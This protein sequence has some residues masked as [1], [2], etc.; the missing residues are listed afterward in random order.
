MLETIPYHEYRARPGLSSGFLRNLL[1]S[2]MHAKWKQDHDEDSSALA[3]GRYVHAAVLE[4]ETVMQC[5]IVKPEDMDRR[6]K[7]GRAAY[8]E[9]QA[10]GKQIVTTAELERGN[11]MCA[12]IMK[13][14]AASK[15][16]CGLAPD[17]VEQSAFWQQGG[18]ECKC[19]FDHVSR[20]E[21]IVDLKTTT[22]ANRYEFEKSIA[23]YGYAVQGCHYLNGALANGLCVNQFIIIAV[24]SE[25]PHGVAV[26]RLDQ[27]YIDAAQEQIESAFAVYKQ[28]IKSGN[29]GGYANEVQDVLCPAWMSTMEVG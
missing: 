8:E 26:Y 13:H 9:L 20:E 4:P 18:L 22:N 3:F 5:F 29:W 28:C 14:P 21:A 6:T 19:R 12:A 25:P 23:H 15:L 16:L 7:A 10:S 17:N 2:P 24:E 27:G 11:A 1:R